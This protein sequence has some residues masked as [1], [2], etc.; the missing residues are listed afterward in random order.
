MVKPANSVVRQRIPGLRGVRYLGP[1]TNLFKFFGMQ[2]LWHCFIEPSPKITESSQRRQA[3]LLSAL[4][5]GLILLAILLE[6]LFAFSIGLEH[7]TGFQEAFITVLGL[8]L[9]YW[10]SR[11]RYVQLAAILAVLGVVLA[12]FALAF[13]DPGN[14]VRGLL[15]YLILPLWLGSL[16]IDL[17]KLPLLIGGVLSA[18]LVLPLAVPAV[19][20][21]AI[22]LGPFSFVFAASLLLIILTYQRNRLEQDRQ[23]ELSAKEQRS[24]REAARAEALLRVAGRLNAQ[25]DLEVVLAAIGEEVSRALHTPVSI[26]SLYDDKQ[27]FLYAAAGVGISPDGLK[28]LLPFP[29]AAFKDMVKRLG[30]IY[31][32]ADLQSVPLISFMDSLKEMDLRSM[33]FAAIEYEHELIGSLS[34][35]TIG[36]RRDFTQEDLLLLQGVAAQAASALVNT[37]LYQD[38]D[39]RLEHLRALRAIELA[40][41]TNRNLRENLDVML[42]KIAR[43][44]KVD[45]AAFL[46]LDQVS[47][48]LE[49]ATSFGFHTPLPPF[50]PLRLGEGIAGRAALEQRIIYIQ[51]MRSDPQTLAFTRAIATEGFVS[52]YAAPLI[53]QENVKGVLEIFHRSV[54]NPDGEWLGFLEALANQAAIAIES[55][56]LFH[57]LQRAVDELSHAYDST[58]EGWS[59][60]LDLRDKETEG[61]TQRVTKMTLRLAH[62]LGFSEET[63][64]HVRRGGLL[65][66]IGKMGIPDSILLK[67]GALSD[68]EWAIMRQ[69]PRLA[70]EMVAPIEYLKPAIDIPY[71]HH[72]KWD[73][74]GYPQGLKGEQIPLAARI[75]AVA[76]VYDA[77][78]SDRPYRKAWS[79]EKTLEHIR[80]LAGT[81]FDPKLVEVLHNLL[82]APRWRAD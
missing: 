16:F 10:L 34:A 46:L 9:V 74:T 38:A 42:D 35:I 69:H 19:T 14:A 39:R 18:L 50:T 23:A 65:H 27:N 55:T 70:Y 4:L 8:V 53:A 72:E 63:L 11:T 58:I 12:V 67:P 36:D 59:R 61:H 44:L 52:F 5:G 54:L 13:F 31:A 62:A 77:L 76:D 15:D 26:V 2:Q 81:H 66:D 64:V 3:S 45:G 7:Y 47:Q 68:D 22:L 32:F 73:G 78:R 82:D 60:A 30:T 48:K 79:K 56:T 80:S 1:Q 28:R 21:D 24:R 25:L 37:R 29:G 51:D 43:Q 40:I 75:F 17:K 20:L 41:A 57:H 71:C 49:L 33:A 6:V